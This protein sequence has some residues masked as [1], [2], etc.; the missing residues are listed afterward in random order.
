MK[1]NYDEHGLIKS[2]TI[3]KDG[4]NLANSSFLN[5][6]VGF[7]EEEREKFNLVGI[8]PDSIETLEQQAHRAYLQIS[9]KNTPLG[10]NI[11]LNSLYDRNETLCYYLL[12]NNIKELLPIAYTPTIGEAVE[13]Y[14]LQARKPKGLFI[15]YENKDRIEE[16][17]DRRINQD[18]KLIVVTDGEGVLGIGDW[19]IGGID[20]SIG[21]LVVYTLCGG[22]N[23]AN[24]L[25]L[26]LDVGTNNSKLLN[27][28]MYLGWKHPRISGKDYDDFI[29]KFV[30]AVKKK[31]PGVLLHWEDF[32]RDNARKNL[33]KYRDSICTFN[34][35]M[36]GTSIMTLSNI[37]SA[38]KSIKSNLKAQKVVMLG[39][40]TAGVG[41]I[42]R[43][44]DAMAR[45]GVSIEDARKNCWL[46]DRQ[47][48]LMSDDKSLV[49]FQ[50]PYGRDRS[51][52]ENWDV[53]N[54]DN[55]TLEEVV[56]NVNPT[57][58]IGCST[59]R[60]A[61]TKDIVKH[62]AECNDR[63]IIMPLSNPTS[64]S[65]AT[66]EDLINWT[67]GRAIVATG[68]PFE[69]V[70]YKNNT[71][72]IAQGNNAFI[73]PGLGLGSLACKATLITDNMLF[74]AAEALSN[75][76]PMLKDPN[77]CLMPD[78][79]DI[80]ECNRVVAKAVIKQAIEDKVTDVQASSD[81]ELEVLINYA[82]WEPK[83]YKYEKK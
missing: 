59:V 15:S 2:I 78:L 39:A 33:E 24:V 45:E 30:A 8:V 21:K 79:T 64:L 20:I 32:G 31:F 77:A 9:S 43:V 62:M 71:Y 81:E 68:S 72:Q 74:A 7:T 53:E 52:I 10:K 83:Y 67:D 11:Y 42:D 22:I 26:Q 28:P 55:I 3:D 4:H 19:G 17:L 44:C 13:N 18:I 48:L 6:G 61:F 16:I 56:R 65:E 47:G 70:H 23:P 49:D 66:A 27:D 54:P 50:K 76:S 38:T 80:K 14:S 37:L 36:Q 82:S 58:L 75:L 29:E 1:F 46:I 34:D 41:C 5:K 51:E 73:Y 60:G 40:G 69:P 63:P 12:Q 25:P 35:D 57:I